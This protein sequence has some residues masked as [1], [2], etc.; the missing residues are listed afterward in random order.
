MLL[1]VYHFHLGT[2]MAVV[3]LERLSLQRLLQPILLADRQMCILHECLAQL[4]DA[5]DYIDGQGALHSL[6]LCITH[7]NRTIQLV[8]INR[9][10]HLVRLQRELH[11]QWQHFRMV[12]Y[13]NWDDDD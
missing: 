1:S 7:L 13:I 2:H 8:K 11:L 9:L 10:L 4:L 6:D 12:P 3:P 5:S